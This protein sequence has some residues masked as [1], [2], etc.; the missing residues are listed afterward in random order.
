MESRLSSLRR[1]PGARASRPQVTALFRRLENLR[2][3]FAVL[4]GPDSPVCG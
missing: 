2:P 4:W 1:N 3:I